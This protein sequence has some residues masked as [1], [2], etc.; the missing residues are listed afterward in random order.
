MVVAVVRIFVAPYAL[1]NDDKC[2]FLGCLLT[3]NT[4]VDNQQ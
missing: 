1:K 2:F 3:K 4:L